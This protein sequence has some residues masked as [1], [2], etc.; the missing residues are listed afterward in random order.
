MTQTAKMGTTMK[1]NLPPSSAPHR[2]SQHQ[3]LG[4]SS[5]DILCTHKGSISEVWACLIYCQQQTDFYSFFLWWKAYW[6]WAT[7]QHPTPLHHEDFLR[8]EQSS[9]D[10][11]SLLQAFYGAVLRLCV[12]FCA[13]EINPVLSFPNSSEPEF[14][15]KQNARKTNPVLLAY[16]LSSKK[17]IKNNKLTLNF[18][19]WWKQ[20]IQIPSTN[21]RNNLS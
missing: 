8:F 9:E 3:F 18:W 16:K 10:S 19:K 13:R 21:H 2:Q 15:W 12:C 17:S 7:Y 5:G 14:R 1:N 4:K 11:G 6:L 20:V